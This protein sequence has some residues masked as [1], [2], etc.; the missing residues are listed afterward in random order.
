MKISYIFKKGD[1]TIGSNY[2]PV[3]ITCVISKVLES[4]IKDYLMS[5]LLDNDIICVQQF[6][7]MLG[8]YTCLQL[9]SILKDQTEACESNTKV[10]IIYHK[11]Y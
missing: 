10:D 5:Y 3:S 1:M 9:L 7:F 11:S 4:I 6:G 2:H 8:R